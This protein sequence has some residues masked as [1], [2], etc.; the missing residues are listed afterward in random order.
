MGLGVQQLSWICEYVGILLK[1]IK[2]KKG[3]GE[4]QNTNWGKIP[5]Y[6]VNV[7]FSLA[8]RLGILT[9]IRG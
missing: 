2:A 6:Y 7:N 4:A 5:L 1:I 8:K 3:K 9:K